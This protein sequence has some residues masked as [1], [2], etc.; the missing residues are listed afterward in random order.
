MRRFLITCRQA[1]A[2]TPLAMARRS[3]LR[4]GKGVSAASDLSKL[5][6]RFPSLS[7]NV[8]GMPAVFADAPGGTQV[9]EEVVRAMARY[10][11]SSNAN[12][13]GA[14][15]TSEETDELIAEARSAGADLVGGA[16][17]EIVF[18]PNMT[19]LNFAL[20]R[21]LARSLGPGDE[22][23]VTVL[24]HDANVAPWLSAARERGA[25]VRWVDVD[26]SDCTLDLDSLDRALGPRT[27]IVA[28]TLASNAVGTI[29][30]A[31]QVAERAR[32]VGAIVVADAVHYAQHR[33][34]DV[35]SLGVD[36]LFCSAYKF[37]GPHLGLMWARRDHLESWEPYKVRPAPEETPER[38]E[39][40]TQNH[41]G[42]AGLVAAVDYLADVG[43]T[44]GDP[45]GDRRGA[46]VAGMEAIRA[47]EGTLGAR[48]LEAVAE[49]PEVRLYGISDVER[50]DERT[51]TFAL[52]IGNRHPREV[53]T[54]L[55]RR[56]VFVWDGN[57]YALAIMERLGLEA[58]GG[59][60]R[61]GFCHYA[62]AEE[63]DRVTDE[64]R[65]LS[66]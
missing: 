6:E 3:W 65:D 50:T 35:R 38:W 44:F 28:F 4:Q 8:N 58:T 43:R 54:E 37:F 2:G 59:A 53:A 36:V 10:L 33:A 64:L 66:A 40:G 51:A 16:P 25:E 47:Y 31:R 63:V 48:F 27:R 24:D 29:T 60:V 19:T 39:T 61:V 42:L 17:G 55:G 62:T 9:P 49:L 21:S 30:A 22:V 45:A 14:F 12:E 57:Y 34:I 26:T 56:G 18:G 15:V 5:R 20:S 23:V 41:E 52:R 1:G 7:R 46:V 32:A 11:G 13:G